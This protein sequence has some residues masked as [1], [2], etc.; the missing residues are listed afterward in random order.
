MTSCAFFLCSLEREQV[1]KSFKSCYVDADD[2]LMHSNFPNGWKGANILSVAQQHCNT[3]MAGF[4]LK[5]EDYSKFKC[6]EI[7]ME[8]KKI[9][10]HLAFHSKRYLELGAEVGAFPYK[11]AGLCPVPAAAACS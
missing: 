4:S 2:Q 10:V 11:K 9:L 6:H 3:S 8:K 1:V 5:P 7:F